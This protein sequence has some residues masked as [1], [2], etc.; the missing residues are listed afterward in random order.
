M[1]EGSVEGREGRRDPRERGGVGA[2]AS[3]ELQQKRCRT[4]AAIVRGSRKAK[5][6]GC[7]ETPA[8]VAVVELAELL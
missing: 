7:S 6:A 1:V 2:P 3:G 5:A 4:D 8:P